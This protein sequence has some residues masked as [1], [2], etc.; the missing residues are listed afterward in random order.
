MSRNELA[1][2]YDI[3]E[4]QLEKMPPPN[5][6][7]H[8][9]A[10]L[11]LFAAVGFANKQHPKK[12]APNTRPNSYVRRGIPAALLCPGRSGQRTAVTASRP[13][14][15]SREHWVIVA[16]AASPHALAVPGELATIT[17]WLGVAEVGAASSGLREPTPRNT[18]AHPRN[19]LW[20]WFAF[21][22]VYDASL[23]FLL[24]GTF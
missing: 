10:E 22:M 5:G 14:R 4:N 8:E 23:W 12:P 7:L 13:A 3:G 6:T 18:R 1:K 16:D 11:I 20:E 24:N 15:S 19:G 9:C 2:F 17:G 21:W